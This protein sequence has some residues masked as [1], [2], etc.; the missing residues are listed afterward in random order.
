MCRQPPNMAAFIA[1]YSH[2]NEEKMLN[3]IWVGLLAVE[4]L[5]VLGVVIRAVV[6]RLSR[7]PGP[8]VLWVRG[9]PHV[10]LP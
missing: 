2:L 4:V 10:R 5:M 1:R 7:K 3:M 9:E 8:A 6:R